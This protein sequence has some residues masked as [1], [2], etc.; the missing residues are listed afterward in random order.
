MRSA[1]GWMFGVTVAMLAGPL[2][3]QL[4]EIAASVATTPAPTRVHF[5]MTATPPALT[6]EQEALIAA[7][8]DR[9]PLPHAT[10]LPDGTSAVTRP[11]SAPLRMTPGLGGAGAPSAAPGT[12]TLFT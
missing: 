4:P 11:D 2:W 10:P 9:G 7:R 12:F 8:R 6:P 3:G 5:D 1:N